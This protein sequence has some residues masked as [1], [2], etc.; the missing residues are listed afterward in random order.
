MGLLGI[1]SVGILVYWILAGL[2]HKPKAQTDA[3][4]AAKR[5]FAG[6]NH[7]LKDVLGTAG[8]QTADFGPPPVD[9]FDDD[10]PN[11]IRIPPV[12]PE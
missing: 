12:D 9:G 6:A 2:L 5:T 7:V 1:L 10:S 3:E 11:T 4:A 8:G